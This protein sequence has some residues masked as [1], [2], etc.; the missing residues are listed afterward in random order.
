MAFH[1][2]QEQSALFH[3]SPCFFISSKEGGSGNEDGEFEGKD[4]GKYQEK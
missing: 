2:E 4:K 1:S 3:L